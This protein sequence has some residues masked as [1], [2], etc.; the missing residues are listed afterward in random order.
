MPFQWPTSRSI[1][2]EAA[3]KSGVASE[4]GMRCLVADKTPAPRRT[5]DLITFS[6]PELVIGLIGESG[7]DPIESGHSR[8]RVRILKFKRKT[9]GVTPPFGLKG[10]GAEPVC[11]I[12]G[13]RLNQQKFR[14]KT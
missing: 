2:V 9:H 1:A 14:A 13:P 7:K 10:E 8:S 3:G 12:A 5:T 6:A 11:H 4:F